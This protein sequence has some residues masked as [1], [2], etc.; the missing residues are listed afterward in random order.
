[1]LTRLQS[2]T[3]RVWYGDCEGYGWNRFYGLFNDGL[4]EAGIQSESRYDGPFNLASDTYEKTRTHLKEGDDWDDLSILML[5]EGCKPDTDY[6]RLPSEWRRI[7]GNES[8]YTSNSEVEVL[9][10]KSYEFALVNKWESMHDESLAEWCEI[11]DRIEIGYK[12][13]RE[14]HTLDCAIMT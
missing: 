4:Y 9:I 3:E 7:L 11:L 14:P 10:S 5:K 8:F 6:Y 2:S 12:K 1:M 13:F